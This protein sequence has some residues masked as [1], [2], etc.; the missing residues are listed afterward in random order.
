MLTIRNVQNPESHLGIHE[1][2]EGQMLWRRNIRNIRLCKLPAKCKKSHQER[3]DSLTRTWSA[4]C[5]GLRWE[6]TL[7]WQPL[8]GHIRISLNPEPYCA[9]HCESTSQS[10]GTLR[11]EG[12]YT[13][14]CERPI[15]RA[16]G[17]ITTLTFARGPEYDIKK[18]G[19]KF[20]DFFDWFLWFLW[21]LWLISSV[22][23]KF[24]FCI[25]HCC[26]IRIKFF[27]FFLF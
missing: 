22:N 9:N 7:L 27:G 17:H 14:K 1:N 15:Q 2:W 24:W 6:G 25:Q 4:A 10:E 16:R 3:L 11:W 26:A 8:W 20:P 18:N 23:F 5:E 19:A 21:F 12:T 13:T